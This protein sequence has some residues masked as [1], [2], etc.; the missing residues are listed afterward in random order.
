MRIVGEPDVL[1]RADNE[2]EHG[3]IVGACVPGYRIFGDRSDSAYP[4]DLT[5]HFAK[6]EIAVRTV[7]DADGIACQARSEVF[8]S[9]PI[10]IDSSD[11]PNRSST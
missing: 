2:T 3:E 11:A 5:L 6:V 10:D 9:G 7:D 4:P 8:Q 1:V